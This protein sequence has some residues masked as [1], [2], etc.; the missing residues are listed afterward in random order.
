MKDTR[1]LFMGTPDFATGALKALVNA[2]ENIIGVITQPDK[3]SGR[4]M[5]MQFS[6]VKKYSLEA[7]LDIYQPTILKNEAIKPLL[8]ELNPDVIIVA[9]YGKIL[10]DYVLNYP[11][12][13]C[14]NIHGSIL[15][16]YRGAAPIQRAVINGDKTTGVTIMQMDSG[17]DTGDIILYREVEI[18]ENTTTG[19]MYDTLSEIGGELI[20]ETMEK[21]RSGSLV[22]TK[23]NDALSTYASKITTE[24]E[25]VDW[26]KSAISIHNT[27]RGLFPFPVAKTTLNGKII[28][29]CS[30]RLC[31]EELECSNA[32]CG[33][34]VK[35][36]KGSVI[37]KCG[38]GLLYLDSMKP[39]G[40]KQLTASDMINGRKIALGDRFE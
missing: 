32:L 23:Q 39:E 31:P 10:P 8:E 11:K 20:V 6:D 30:S 12:Y 15:P 2:G 5:K 9:A 4:G 3:A 1:I 27:I 19:E 37:V 34:I 16:K 25:I 13:G 40:S 14:I 33:E 29:L 35:A 28:K 7:G 22:K 36:S 26:S 24:D 18:G 21:I 38:E 17:L